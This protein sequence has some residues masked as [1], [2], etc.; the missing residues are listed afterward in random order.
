MSKI[1]NDFYS[2]QDNTLKILESYGNKI[3]LIKQNKTNPAIA[4]N[5]GISYA[6][7]EFISFCDIDDLFAENK[8]QLQIETLQKNPDIGSNGCNASN[9]YF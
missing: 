1:T 6:N 8:I 2:I 5:V 3:K 4:R 9:M 7:G